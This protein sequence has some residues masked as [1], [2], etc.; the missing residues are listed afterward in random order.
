MNP[1]T[2]DLRKLNS[3]T[4]YP[5]IPTYHTIDPA[6]R[7]GGLLEEVQ[8]RF[9]GAVYGT[10]KV[11]GVNARIILMPGGGWVIGSREEL[12]TANGDIVANM[13]LG[14]VEALAGMAENA[15][16]TY[17]RT[18]PVD[19]IVV[20]YAEMYGLKPQ[21]AWKTYGD[22]RAAAR[23]FDVGLVRPSMLDMPVE[24]IASWRDHGAQDF[25]A[26]PGL[27]AT[28][29][30]VSIP[31]VPRLFEVDAQDLPTTVADMHQFVVHHS[32]VT[33]VATA[34]TGGWSEGIVL[35]SADRSVIAK[36]R[37]QD[38]LRT[39]RLKREAQ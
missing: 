5:S 1:R 25:L 8:V 20:L 18:L 10:E 37:H 29:D 36:A 26:E 21:P 35:R 11:D 7:K 22:G 12:L 19:R 39:L 15:A 13:S 30:Y 2:V 9:E 16:L 28:A 24:Q 4:K 31:A 27:L 32:N 23:L 38:Y 6:P 3:A 33:R 17:R 14:I 34:G